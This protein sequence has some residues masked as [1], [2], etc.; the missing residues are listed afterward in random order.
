MK[1]K[2]PD[3]TATGV[4]AIAALAVGAV[5]IWKGS[6]VIGDAVTW[7]GEKVDAAKTA[8]VDTA[9]LGVSPLSPTGILPTIGTTI[10]TGWPSIEQQDWQNKQ[11]EVMAMGGMGA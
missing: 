4:I 2:A 6:K 11:L 3:I 5:I 1:I 7:V 10:G 9:K 8:V